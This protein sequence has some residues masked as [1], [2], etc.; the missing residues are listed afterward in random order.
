VGN[1]SSNGVFQLFS[2]GWEKFTIL[3]KKKSFRKKKFC[4]KFLS[5]WE[6]KSPKIRFFVLKTTKNHHYCL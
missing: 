3:Q 2:F 1:I 5:F 6:K 4:H